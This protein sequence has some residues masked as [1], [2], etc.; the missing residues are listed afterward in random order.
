MRE[1]HWEED[2]VEGGAHDAE[3]GSVVWRAARRATFNSSKTIR[4]SSS[5]AKQPKWQESV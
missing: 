5:V 2:A 3:E 1:E 4:I